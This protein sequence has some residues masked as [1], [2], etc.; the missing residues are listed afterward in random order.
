M[1]D[2]QRE[3]VRAMVERCRRGDVATSDEHRRQVEVW[4]TEGTV[5]HDDVVATMLEVL[6]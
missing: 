3:V 6:P 1:T 4:I 2:A 5:T